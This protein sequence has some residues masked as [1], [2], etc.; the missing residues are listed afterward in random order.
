[1]AVIT[2]VS[3][4]AKAAAGSAKFVGYTVIA[5]VV[6]YSDLM[7]VGLLWNAFPGGFLSILALGG[8][9]ATGISIIALVV[10]KARWFRP[11]GQLIWSWAFTGIE[12][13]ISLMNIVVSVMVAKGEPLGQYLSVWLTVAPATPIVAALG[14]IVIFYLDR[15]REQAHEQMEMEDDLSDAE[16]EHKRQV[17]AV[18]M[19]LKSIALEQQKEYLRQHLASSEVQ[20]VL[21]AGSYEIARGIVSEII[22]RPIMPAPPTQFIDSTAQRIDTNP[23]QPVAKP[24]PAPAPP[25]PKKRLPRLRRLVHTEPLKGRHLVP[26]SRPAQTNH[27]VKVTRRPETTYTVNKSPVN[28]GL[29][30]HD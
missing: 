5:L 12:A 28:Q 13:A 3:R 17:H 7:F 4:N 8:A 24:K 1:M 15:E 29:P 25:A 10:G 30:L 27:Q 20:A 26:R 21:S 14:W 16:R 11:G 23:R 19:E 6:L 18:R 22:Q 9:F 2:R